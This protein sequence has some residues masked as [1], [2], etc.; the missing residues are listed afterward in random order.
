M[1]MDNLKTIND[2]YGHKAGDRVLKLLGNLLLEYSS[3][4]LVCRLG[5]DEFLLFMPNADQNSITEVITAIFKKFNTQRNKILS[6]MLHPFL[7]DYICAILEILLTN[8]IQ[9]LIK[10]YI[11]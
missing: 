10:H 3:E 8:V 5:G 2:I 1:D 6:F 11:S 7:P 9:K 4:C